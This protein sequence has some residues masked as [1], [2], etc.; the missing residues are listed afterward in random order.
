VA[1]PFFG[2]HG[3][4]LFLA[5]ALSRAGIREEGLVWTNANDP[6]F[7]L[8]VK[9]ANEVGIRRVVALGREAEKGLKRAGVQAFNVFPVRHPQAVQRFDHDGID[10]YASE[11]RAALG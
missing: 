2:Y 5:E 8:V 9:A 3:S 11:L 1:W 6:G 4:S 10:K 7:D